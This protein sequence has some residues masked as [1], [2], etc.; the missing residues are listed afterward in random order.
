MVGSK[1][2]FSTGPFRP[3]IFSVDDAGAEHGN[4]HFQPVALPTNLQSLQ[5]VRL[6]TALGSIGASGGDRTRRGISKLKAESVAPVGLPNG[7]SICGS[8]ACRCHR[9]GWQKVSGAAQ[10]DH[11][12]GHINRQ[13]G[14]PG[15]GSAILLVMGAHG[16]VFWRRVTASADL[17]FLCGRW[18][19][20][21]H[22][23]QTLFHSRKRATASG[24]GD[25]LYRVC[26]I[27]LF[28]SA[29]NSAMVIS[30]AVSSSGCA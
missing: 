13:R 16:D 30:R 9:Q 8:N 17:S 12:C 20:R 27:S 29:S 3:V 10:D 1:C 23:A 24:A 21:L 15:L 22:S 18:N 14:Y 7:T 11:Q 26:A 6:R 4:V 5:T 19:A 28:H 2:P 25:R